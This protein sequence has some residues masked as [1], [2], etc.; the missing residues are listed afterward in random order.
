MQIWSL[1]LS[2]FIESEMKLSPVILVVFMSHGYFHGCLSSL[3]WERGYNWINLTITCCLTKSVMKHY[4][5]RVDIPRD[6]YKHGLVKAS[7]FLWEYDGNLMNSLILFQ[8]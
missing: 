2:G 7:G 6:A 5:F 4:S 1:Y 3:I 8:K